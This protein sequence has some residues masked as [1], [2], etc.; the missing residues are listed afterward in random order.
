MTITRAAPPI[1]PGACPR[2]HGFVERYRDP[3]D[4]QTDA[5]ANCGWVRPPADEL[6]RITT[7]TSVDVPRTPRGGA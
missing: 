3:R 5:C 6:A 4:G 2:C 7:P 1:G